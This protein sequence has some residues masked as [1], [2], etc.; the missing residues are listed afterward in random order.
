MNSV[1]TSAT[2]FTGLLIGSALNP[3]GHAVQ[4]DAYRCA[5]KSQA[6]MFGREG[7]IAGTLPVGKMN[8]V[9]PVIL[10]QPMVSC[11]GLDE[12]GR[13]H[14]FRGVDLRQGNQG[15]AVG[16]VFF[17]PSLPGFWRRIFSAEEETGDFVPGGGQGL[18][19]GGVSNAGSAIADGA[20]ELGAGNADF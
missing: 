17:H 20:D 11:I 10:F 7:V 18:G 16:L 9:E 14:Q 4:A 6:M 1:S 12:I 13:G 3:C 8:D 5:A 2:S 15:E 19:H